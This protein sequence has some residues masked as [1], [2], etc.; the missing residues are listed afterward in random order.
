MMNENNGYVIIPTTTFKKEL[1][2]YKK[3]PLKLGK[4]QEIVEILNEKGF[5]GIP[6]NKKPHSLVGNYKDCYECHIEPDLLII[7]KQYEED[8]V[9]VLER[10][11]SHSELFS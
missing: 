3:Q 5:E 1:K 8:K 6:K 10:L 7:W 4:I 11:G 9:I 2:K